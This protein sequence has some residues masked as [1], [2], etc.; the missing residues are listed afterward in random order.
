MADSTVKIRIDME[1][2]EAAFAAFRNIG[3]LSSSLATKI[4]GLGAVLAGAAGLGSLAA[5]AVHVAKLGGELQDL[6]TR[7]GLSTQAAMILGQAFKDSGVP[8]E[9]LGSSVG[10]LQKA[11]YEAATAGGAASA[12]FQ[13]IG[14][15]SSELLNLAPEDQFQ[16]VSAAI[17]G[18]ENP[19]KRSAA[20]IAIFGKAGT[21]L[22]PLFRDDG[23]IAGAKGA[24]G[25]LPDVMARNLPVLDSISDRLERIPLKATQFFAGF[26]DGVGQRFDNLLAR[27][28]SI[29]LTGFGQNVAAVVNLTI[30]AFDEG[31]LGE[32]IGLT[33]E[34][35]AELGTEAFKRMVSAV[36]GF[37]LNQDMANAIGNFSVSLVAGI[38]KAFVSVQT[39]FEGYFNALA[40]Y[41]GQAFEAV[42]RSVANRF[43]ANTETVLNGMAA[44]ARSLGGPVAGA[45]IPKAISLPRVSETGTNFDE[46][47]SKGIQSAQQKG[48]LLSG[49][50]DAVTAQY[51]RFFDITAQKTDEDGKQVTAAEKLAAMIAKMKA[52]TEALKTLPKV[53]VSAPEIAAFNL[54]L[55]LQK[56]ELDLAQKLQAINERKGAIE[57]SWL[58]SS[59]EKYRQKRGLLAGELQLLNEQISKLQ[60]LRAKAGTEEERLQIDQKVSS[61]Q[62]QRAGVQ[63][64]ITGMGPDPESFSQQ[65]AATFQRIQDQWGTFATQL[66]TS[67][68]SVFENAI[69]SISSGITGL[70]MR[71]QTWGQA[72]ANIGTSILTSVVSAIV[73]MGVR[74]IATQILMATVGRSILA[75]SVAATAPI[76]AAQSAIWAAP[77]TLATIASYGSAAAAAPGLIALAQGITMAQSVAQFA[78]GGYTGAGGKYEVA[79][80]VHRG[81]YVVP[82]EMVSRLS[83]PG[84]ESML[85]GGEGSGAPA[86]AAASAPAPVNFTMG[87]YHDK[88]AVMDFLKSQEGRAFF[89]DLARQH[90]HEINA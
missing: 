42:L 63:N 4:A 80:V 39:F 29:D 2:A 21:E 25:A 38:G 74:Y 79:G 56:L 17:A 7:T 72:L 8:A 61:L 77:A 13:D 51:R 59:V 45:V 68:Q 66:A 89:V 19:A 87:V 62:G 64:G 84:I 16:K 83:V 75:A 49:I 35:G 53:T 47:L 43:A 81:E 6:T 58:T 85:Y 70:I 44:V 14:L 67:F 27:I 9:A 90:A 12:A 28:E 24:L 5:A 41:A 88:A 18:I 33:I 73:N 78:E 48:Q 31:R 52:D 65:F 37:F 10:K 22:L 55:E 86:P 15:S 69:G 26:F 34:A 32:F 57:S 50:I 54:K 60:E 30:K 46:A 20:A 3:N 1:G 40:V 36:T 11:I 76:A 23:A 71:T 82:A